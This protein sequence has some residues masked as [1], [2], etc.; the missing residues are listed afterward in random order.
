[1]EKR[2]W[3]KP[4]GLCSH[5]VKPFLKSHGICHLVMKST[6][7]PHKFSQHWACFWQM[8]PA[9]KSFCKTCSLWNQGMCVDP[10][11]LRTYLRCRK[12]VPFEVPLE[13]LSHSDTQ[14][15]AR[16]TCGRDFHLPSSSH[17]VCTTRTHRSRLP[18]TLISSIKEVN[19]VS[20]TTGVFTFSFRLPL[21]SVL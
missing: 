7:N 5:I 11:R 15:A 8:W 3:N 6:F 12:R 14:W 4:S 2:L 16:G 20:V 10:L 1:M 17:T 19:V 21:M 13:T 9:Y 18:A